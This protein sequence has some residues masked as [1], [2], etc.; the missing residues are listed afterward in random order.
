MIEGSCLCGAVRFAVD[1]RVSPLQYCHCR[2]CQKASGG[3][4]VAAVA[5]RT[6]DIRWLAGEELVEVFALPVRDAPPPY[7]TAFCR[8]CGAPVPIVDPSRPF[9]VIPA[10]AFDGQPEL[11]PLRHIFVSLNP[12]WYAIRDQLPQFEQHVPPEQR[13]PTK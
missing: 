11:T 13:L 1:G 6:G 12:P 5:A 9:A 7:R 2:R 4:F 10:G 8:C 3:A